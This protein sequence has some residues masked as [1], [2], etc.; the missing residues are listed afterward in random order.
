MSELISLYPIPPGW[1]L[2]GG[3][4]VLCFLK[5]SWRQGVAI[6]LACMAL[7]WGWFLP[8]DSSWIVSLNH[9]PWRSALGYDIVFMQISAPTRLFGVAFALLTVLGMI[10]AMTQRNRWEPVWALLY[11]GG[12]LS[13]IYA[14]DL[15]TFFVYWEGM[16][17][18]SALLIFSSDQPRSGKAGMRYLLVHLLGGVILLSGICAHVWQM[19]S[20]L[21]SPDPVLMEGNPLAYL[22]LLDT[23]AAVLMLIGLLINAGVPVLTSWMQDAYPEASFSGAVF[24]SGMTSKVAIFALLM[25]FS[26]A[27]VLFGVGALM[28]VYGIVYGLGENDL[29]R[30][31]C[32]SIISQMGLMVCVV[33]VGSPLAV[34][35]VALYALVHILYKALLM[36]TAGAVLHS[37]G[38]RQL[39]R[40][41]GLAQQMP[42]V[43]AA[44]WIGGLTLCALPLT[45]GYHAKNLLLAALQ[46]AA[47]EGWYLLLLATSALGLIYVGFRFPWLVFM[48][49]KRAGEVGV[50]TAPPVSMHVAMGIAVVL[51]VWIGV[52]P[53]SVYSLL[54]YALPELAHASAYW[55]MG[56]LVRQLQMLCVAAVLFYGWLP[57]MVPRAGI[58]LE[59]DWLYRRLIPRVWWCLVMPAGR[60]LWQMESR[61][62]QD[63]P[64]YLKTFFM[65]DRIDYQ[66]EGQFNLDEKQT[67]LRLAVR[68]DRKREWSIGGTLLVLLAILAV[69]LILFFWRRALGA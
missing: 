51:L 59:V 32:F 52:F 28:A 8:S 42:W 3:A 25:F 21:I 24:L 38:C 45:A 31:L 20:V 50:E 61:L 22:R 18:A 2:I 58:L 36:M 5:G 17:L 49:N 43:A 69:Y 46:S 67:A 44:A 63:I 7:L 60:R 13:V 47:Q 11:A 16:A 55:D 34:N 48:G 39:S 29:R 37:T 23:P 65:P 56:H 4:A 33:G 27:D 30:L 26:G 57:A 6:G 10:Y 53:L 64:R 41:G 19:H 62:G 68:V 14:G 9:L 1:W 54:P 12:A 35:A 15:V 40:L 66:L